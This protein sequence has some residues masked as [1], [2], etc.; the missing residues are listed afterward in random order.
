MP[1][2]K[3]S[4]VTDR[5]RDSLSK[6]HAQIEAAE[7]LLQKMP[8]ANRADVK[9]REFCDPE[10]PEYD[11]YLGFSDSGIR[12]CYYGLDQYGDHGISSTKRLDDLST[13][14]RISASKYVPELIR[15]AK[16][17]EKDVVKDADDIAQSIGQAMAEALEA[18]E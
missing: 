9:I 14:L 16:A 15:L 17:A 18:G 10:S 8:G 6:M 12:V 2:G 3:K 7:K 5:L 11:V 4:A 1:K 13:A